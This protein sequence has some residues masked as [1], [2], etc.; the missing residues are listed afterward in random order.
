MKLPWNRKYLVI[1]LHAAATFGAMYL[2]KLLL[3]AAAHIFGSLPDFGNDVKEFLG[4]LAG[5]FSPLV[6]A[7][8]AAYLLDP[9]VD[10]FQRLYD[11]ALKGRIDELKLKVTRRKRPEPE[12]RSRAAGAALAYFAFLSV[13]G[14]FVVWIAGKLNI[15][16]DVAS[17]MALAAQNSLASF[18]TAYAGLQKRLEEID[19]LSFASQYL[20]QIIDAVGYFLQNLS[21]S[22][23]SS[24]SNAGGSILNFF[25]GLILAFYLLSGKEK[26]LSGA[27]KV[28]KVLLPAKMRRSVSSVASD[29][30]HVLMGYMR[31]I[32]TDVLIVAVMISVYLSIIK[33]EFAIALGVITGLANIVPYF[34]AFFGLLLSVLVALLSGDPWKALYAGIGIFVLQQ[35]DGMIINPRVVA[36]SVELSPIAVIVALSVAGSLFGIAGMILAAPACAILKLFAMRFIEYKK[37]EKALAE[38]GEPGA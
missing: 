17:S 18:V 13:L 12:F 38:F 25:L 10:F 24:L 34:G 37:R 29:I 21:T 9:A 8:I 36:N 6:I 22:L 27:A 28:A 32:F 35:I 1:G 2:L 26:L 15:E 11:K 30:H 20:S 23:I 19:V 4:W 33:V 7:M 3:D 31:G 14:L 16:D 5:L